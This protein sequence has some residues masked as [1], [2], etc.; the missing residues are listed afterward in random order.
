MYQTPPRH[1]RV[2]IPYV[3]GPRKDQSVPGWSTTTYLGKVRPTCEGEGGRG[4][5]QGRRQQ[6]GKIRLS[7]KRR[8][9]AP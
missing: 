4:L 5:L 7:P 9:N 8:A 6:R 2:V 1:H 3:D